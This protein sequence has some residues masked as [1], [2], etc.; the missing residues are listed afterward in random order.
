MPAIVE[1]AA[2]YYVEV[3]LPKN[4]ITL[5]ES[6]PSGH[7]F[8]TDR[9]GTDCGTTSKPY[10]LACGY[11]QAGAALSAIYDKLNPRAEV[12]VGTLRAFDQTPF[13]KDLANAGLA[14]TGFVYVPDTCTAAAHCRVEIVF[15]GC[16]QSYAA[17]GDTAMREAGFAAWADTNNL[18]VL[19]PQVAAGAATNPEG[20][21]DWWGYTGRD[22][23]TR[24]APQ[25]KAVHRMLERLAE[26]G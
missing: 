23:L 16:R 1:A 10:V 18:I 19:Y 26:S 22:Y 4:R 11:D 8:V 7:G 15:H 13:T 6:I 5:V 12:P 24:E 21:W 20:C 2:A 25:I 9:S 3:G 14:D 17:V